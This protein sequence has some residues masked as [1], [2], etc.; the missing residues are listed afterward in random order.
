[1]RTTKNRVEQLLQNDVELRSRD[2]QLL[3]EFWES[4]GLL[5]NEIQKRTF[6]EKCTTPE[7]ITRARRALRSKYP[8]TEAVEQERFNQML[9]YRE[10]YLWSQRDC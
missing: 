2:K 10:D 3:L 1:M 4:E 7:S 9:E 5:L 6:L 8:G